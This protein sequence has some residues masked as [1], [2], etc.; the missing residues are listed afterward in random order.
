M[1]SHALSL[2]IDDAELYGEAP[3][4]ANGDPYVAVVMTTNDEGVPI[5][6]DTI[7]LGTGFESIDDIA[8]DLKRRLEQPDQFDHDI[9]FA[10]DRAEIFGIAG[11]VSFASLTQKQE[12]TVELE[13][14]SFTFE[15]ESELDARYRAASQFKAQLNGPYVGTSV[16]EFAQRATI[17]NTET[18]ESA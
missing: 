11:S 18:A 9:G 10:P 7:T 5:E 6:K 15:A 13:G 17:A 2:E 8:G 4:P 3:T 12:Y 14:E 16:S 1:S